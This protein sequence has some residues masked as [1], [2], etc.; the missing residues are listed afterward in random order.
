VICRVLFPAILAARA[1][2]KALGRFEQQLAAVLRWEILWSDS[3]AGFQVPRDGSARFALHW[4]PREFSASSLSYCSRDVGVCARYTVLPQRNWM[5]DANAKRDSSESDIDAVAAF[6]GLKIRE[7]AARTGSP[8]TITLGGP[9]G[10]TGTLTPNSGIAWT[11][12]ISLGGRE[13]IVRQY[14]QMRPPEIEGLKEWIR[15]PLMPRDAGIKSITIACFAPSDPVVYYSVDGPATKPVIMAVFWDR[16]LEEW[17]VATYLDRTQNSAVFERM[18]RTI[19]SIACSTLS[20][21]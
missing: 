7:P 5:R 19:E 20:F 13:E 17:R 9:G 11:A 18:H 12:T 21:P 1:E 3:P 8:P 15:S 6:D 16:D 2:D 4:T 10:L 14:R